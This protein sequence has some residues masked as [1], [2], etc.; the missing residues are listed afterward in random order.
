MANSFGFA[1]VCLTFMVGAVITVTL[2]EPGLVLIMFLFLF[3]GKI[4]QERLPINRL[5]HLFGFPFRSNQEISGK[6]SKI[7]LLLFYIFVVFKMHLK[8]F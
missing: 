4:S 6:E 2:N 5:S 7:K 8:R 3:G 1:A